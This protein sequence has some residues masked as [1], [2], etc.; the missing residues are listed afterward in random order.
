MLN[1]D[2]ML[3][4]YSDF[5]TRL[6]NYV[7]KEESENI[8]SSIGEEKLINAPFAHKTDTG[9]AYDGSLIETILNI[10]TFAIKINQ[11]LPSNKQA[12]VK[13]IVKVGLLHHLSKAM[14]YI[15]NDS[16]WEINNRGLVYKFNDE[17]EGALR[18]GERST[19]L[20]C[21]AGVKFT[22]LEFEAM[23]VNDKDTDDTYSKY[24]SSSLSMVIRQANEI[25]TNIS[26]I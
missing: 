3:K 8:I 11:L 4:N 17:L 24:Y 23:R 12:D 19:L 6:E 9:F 2:L 15:P 20:A 5:K 18:V 10:T 21:N 1:Q 14:L 25:L 26:K 22:E 16:S 13:S 7:G